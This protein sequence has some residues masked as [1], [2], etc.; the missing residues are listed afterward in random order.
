MNLKTR[1]I[2]SDNRS[3]VEQEEKLTQAQNRLSRIRERLERLKEHA[4]LQDALTEGPRNQWTRSPCRSRLSHP[5]EAE[6]I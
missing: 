1:A 6:W 3:Q 4:N 2:S 5:L